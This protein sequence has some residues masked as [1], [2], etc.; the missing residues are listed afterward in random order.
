MLE[1]DEGIPLPS[2]EI[3][4]L[5]EEPTIQASIVSI[6]FHEVRGLRACDERSGWF[7]FKGLGPGC[8]LFDF[9]TSS[10]RFLGS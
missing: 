7:F 2:P 1:T 10:F 8:L 9:E 6:L 5:E 4:P 3:Y